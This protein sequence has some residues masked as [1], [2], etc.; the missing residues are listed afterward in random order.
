M[1]LVTKMVHFTEINIITQ[2]TL[3]QK[4]IKQMLHGPLAW[5]SLPD[6]LR[7]TSISRDSFCKL[8]KLYLLTLYWNIE[9]IRSFTYL[10]TLYPINTMFLHR[11]A[12]K[13]CTWQSTNHV[14]RS[15]AVRSDTRTRSCIRC[16]MG[17]RSPCRHPD[18]VN[19]LLLTGLIKLHTSTAV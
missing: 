3:F 11:T 12:Q 18:V 8:L 10:L 6:N 16:S 4:L 5:N 2:H 17:G 15:V 13:C 9:C 7:K 14:W 1:H 19:K